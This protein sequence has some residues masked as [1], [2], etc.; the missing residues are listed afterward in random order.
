MLATFALLGATLAWWGLQL[1][2][3]ALAIAPAGSLIDTTGV[4]DITAAQTLFGSSGRIRPAP[5]EQA[6]DIRVLGIAAGPSRA[7]AVLSIG[8]GAA[9]AWAAGDEIGDD[10]RLVEIDGSKV[11]LE[12]NGVR[13]ELAAPERPSPGLLTSAAG[14]DQPAAA[15]PR[16]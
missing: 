5:G 3:P 12:Q 8:A 13:V 1:L 7:S 16:P 9:R 10:L 4:P 14:T 6:A 2:A 15:N 11:V